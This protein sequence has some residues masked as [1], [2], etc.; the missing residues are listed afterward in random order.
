MQA[1]GIHTYEGRFGNFAYPVSPEVLN[2]LSDIARNP[3][4]PSTPQTESIVP[5]PI[6]F[7][8]EWY[9]GQFLGSTLSLTH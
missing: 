5:L 2:A 9:T 4:T 3:P 8:P 1:I 7:H 6:M